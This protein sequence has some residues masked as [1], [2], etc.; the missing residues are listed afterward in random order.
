MLKIN[1]CQLD[2]VR[3]FNKRI[4]MMLALNLFAVAKGRGGEG[5]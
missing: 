2:S 5:G 1:F 3:F 4:R